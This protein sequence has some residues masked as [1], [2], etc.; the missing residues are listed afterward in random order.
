MS[1]KTAT[2][3]IQGKEGNR[4]NGKVFLITEM[5]AH[6]AERWALRAGFAL[7]NA[8]A[9]IPELEEGIGMQ[10]LAALGLRVLMG[11][12][13]GVSFEKAEPLLEDMMKCAQSIPDP[14]KPN[15]V[16]P[17]IESDIEEVS[18]RLKLRKEIWDLHVGFFIQG[19]Q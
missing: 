7:M 19:G 1:R 17:L 11:A 13:Q 4:D 6:E 10:E 9:D 18:T 3:T 15:V 14:N 16:R 2:I 12:L 8:G 5:S